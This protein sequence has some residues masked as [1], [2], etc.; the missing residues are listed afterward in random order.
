MG[1]H[2]KHRPLVI[3]LAAAPL[4][5]AAATV[6][7][8]PAFACR[9]ALALALDIST[10]VD[11]AEYELQRQG[12][13]AALGAPDVKAAILGPA[14]P[15]ALAIYEWSGTRHQTIKVDWTLIDSEA[16]LSGVIAT[17]G[18]IS[19]SD[20][21]FPTGLGQA[22]GFGA[23]LL[24]NA[25]ACERRVID[26][27]G[28]GVNNDGYPPASAYRHFP[29]DGVTVNG[30]VIVE[31]GPDPTGAYKSVDVADYYRRE[32]IRGPGAFLEIAEGF[33]D[34]ERAMRR[35]LLREIAHVAIGRLE[36][37]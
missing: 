3:R 8:A 36:A 23:I 7:P 4:L 15:V 20:S 22:L 25:P 30:L 12:L 1:Q 11:A 14:G 33:E 18:G 19:R 34:F 31:S 16:R 10:S 24:R 26:V 13:M 35:K 17:L 9:L 5:A 21:E 2:G 6:S 28:D 27:S 32:V 37:R 29:F